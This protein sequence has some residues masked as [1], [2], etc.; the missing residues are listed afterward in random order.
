M[1]VFDYGDVLYMHASLSTLKPLDAVY[2]NALR[3]ITGDDYRTHHC[4][5]YE[6]VGWPS[7]TVRREQ[8]CIC[9]L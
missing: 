4:L 8:H 7:L 6:K 3:F 2:H 5:L 1:S 9:Y